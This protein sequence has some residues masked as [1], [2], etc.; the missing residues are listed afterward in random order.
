MAFRLIDPALGPN[1]K[2]AGTLYVDDVQLYQLQTN[3]FNALN[4]LNGNF[5]L[6]TIDNWRFVE[7]GPSS[8][9]STA[10]IS[11]TD[12]H[13]GR[14]AANITW[15]QS[16][17]ITEL[18]F[19]QYLNITPGVTYTYSAW[20]KSLSGPF[21]LQISS[22]FIDASSKVISTSQGMDKSWILSA[23]YTQHSFVLPTAPPEATRLNIGFRAFN[24]DGSRW[25]A[26]DVE[27]LIDD[28]QLNQPLTSNPSAL[29]MLHQVPCQIYPNPATEYINIQSS[30]KLQSASIYSI[31][32][33]K[34][35]DI[36]S[37]FDNINISDL[38]S[39]IYFVK[40]N[41]DGVDSTQKLV[42]K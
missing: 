24:A 30:N 10:N 8:P 32:G 4:S 17:A 38:L 6:G 29:S 28:V 13:S 21:I 41:A 36:N 37:K 27:C 3:S 25:P 33:Q 2:A 18:L 35:K 5:E 22:A 16:A 15:G 14:Y 20:A 9:I 19:D 31:S 42:I 11:S 39:G 7:L 1:S 34:V 12:A 26:T 40:V 23:D